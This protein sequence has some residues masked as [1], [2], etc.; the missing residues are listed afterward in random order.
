M[1]TQIHSCL[2]NERAH[3]RPILVD[4][5]TPEAFISSFTYPLYNPLLRA[6]SDVGE[7]I[8]RDSGRSQ[9]PDNPYDTGWTC[10]RTTYGELVNVWERKEQT[11][12]MFCWLLCQFP[13]LNPSQKV[14]RREKVFKLGLIMTLDKRG[15]NL[16]RLAFLKGPKALLWVRTAFVISDEKHPFKWVA[17]ILLALPN[18]ERWKF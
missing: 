17:I 4:E 18:V 14:D 13:V 3:L 12:P 10:E 1:Y 7:T 15:Y 6:M 11:I 2:G 5:I 8:I 16:L 9:R